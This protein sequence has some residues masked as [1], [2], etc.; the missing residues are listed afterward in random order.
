[1]C[2]IVG[3]IGKKRSQ[4]CI[5]NG[6][7]KLEYRGYDSAGFACLDEIEGKLR[8]IKAKGSIENLVSKIKENSFDGPVGI[9]H[10]RWSTHGEASE[11]NAHPHFDPKKTVSIVHNGIIENYSKL[12][13]E[14]IS[15]GHTFY[16]ETDT[17]VI[18]H[19]LGLELSSSNFL[20][21]AV[22]KLTSKL[23]GAYVFAALLEKHPD[24]ML[25][26]RKSSP[27][28]IGIGN[29]ETFVA[30]DFA[31]F[32]DYTSKVLFL[33]DESFAIVRAKNIEIYDFDGNFLS[34]KS[35]IK[36]VNKDWESSG[37]NGI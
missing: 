1:M 19:L 16:S 13:S 37:K 25:V 17:E 18:A 32:S 26:V 29:G 35:Q 5:V 30:S 8:Y 9:G 14:L 2:G 28:C 12:K 27:L 24:L 6:L 22:I 31:A 15:R 23:R 36:S 4:N 34:V 10:T 3:Y 21:E 20:K 33:P 7:K 11:T